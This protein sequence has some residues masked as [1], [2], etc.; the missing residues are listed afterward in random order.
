MANYREFEGM[1][2]ELASRAEACR[3]SED[4]FALIAG[5]WPLL[6][7]AL[8]AKTEATARRLYDL[9][10]LVRWLFANEAKPWIQKKKSGLD[11]QAPMR[12][13]LDDPSSLV[14]LRDLLRVEIDSC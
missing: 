6:P 1:V 10:G 5:A 14:G 7:S 12:L 8:H 4:E 3:K 9:S 11:D 13:L 2:T